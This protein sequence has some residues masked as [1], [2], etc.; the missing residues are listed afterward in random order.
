LRWLGEAGVDPE[1]AEQLVSS[2]CAVG[3]MHT[4][5]PDG[6]ISTP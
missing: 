2:R 1:A 4:C 6:S 3:R 5:G